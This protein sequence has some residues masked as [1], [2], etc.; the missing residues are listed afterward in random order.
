MAHVREKCTT[1]VTLDLKKNS[2]QSL[3]L[4]SIDTQ[5]PKLKGDDVHEVPPSP[6]KSTEG[7][8][9]GGK[10]TLDF[11]NCPKGRLHVEHAKECHSACCSAIRFQENGSLLSS[12]SSKV[13]K[14]IATEGRIPLATILENEAAQEGLDTDKLLLSTRKKKMTSVSGESTL[15]TTASKSCMP[16]TFRPLLVD[17]VCFSSSFLSLFP[18]SLEYFTWLEDRLLPSMV[19]GEVP[20]TLSSLLR[21]YLPPRVRLSFTS[22][23]QGLPSAPL[24]VSSKTKTSLTSCVSNELS[25]TASTISPEQKRM[26]QEQEYFDD[27]RA[28]EERRREKALWWAQ[29]YEE[30]FFARSL[31]FSSGLLCCLIKRKALGRQAEVSLRAS[32]ALPA[33]ST[34]D[35][36]ASLA[37]FSYAYYHGFPVS[38]YFFIP[39]LAL[40]IF[41]V[42]RHK[43]QMECSKK[44]PSEKEDHQRQ[45][46]L[47]Q[48]QISHYKRREPQQESCRKGSVQQKNGKEAFSLPSSPFF[49]SYKEMINEVEPV[50]EEELQR[51]NDSIVKMMDIILQDD[52]IRKIF[53]KYPTN[54]Q[55]LLLL[56]SCTLLAWK[57]VDAGASVKFLHSYA[58]Q[59]QT[60]PFTTT[61]FSIPRRSL[62]LQHSTHYPPT[63]RSKQHRRPHSFERKLSPTV[64]PIAECHPRLSSP[65]VPVCS[66]PS[67]GEERNCLDNFS[68][69][70]RSDIVHMERFVFRMTKFRIGHPPL[71]WRVAV[72]L[73]RLYFADHCS[74]QIK[75]KVDQLK[76]QQ[77]ER[78][79]GLLEREEESSYSPTTLVDSIRSHPIDPAFLHLEQKLLDENAIFMHNGLECML[80]DMMS[81][82]LLPSSRASLQTLL[83][84]VFSST[85]AVT[86]EKE[87]DSTENSTDTEHK[88]HSFSEGCFVCSNEKSMSENSAT[89]PLLSHPLLGF[90]LAARHGVPI[91]WMLSLTTEGEREKFSMAIQQLLCFIEAARKVEDGAGSSRG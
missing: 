72:E 61:L 80:T 31:S 32:D 25:F 85:A 43:M 57:V 82:L 15:F 28:K 1:K 91:L 2:T 86:A 22:L 68:F 58:T 26:S 71:W 73:F 56:V 70:S 39:F 78:K 75:E 50:V 34:K 87:E 59:R 6:P 79:M 40:Q 49:H 66:R 47:E 8:T 44:S 23:I 33:S 62:L 30:E 74:A 11:R 51:N 13:Q 76:R 67:L 48:E 27:E 90:A 37:S 42:L 63:D 12:L 24:P 10:R 77:Q 4:G 60:H 52:P 89:S 46:A 83:S 41:S 18:S 55:T 3:P 38:Q 81:F 35:P 36:H 45:Y 19:R 69:V 5:K 17:K 53:F 65:S 54:T 64:L 7:K 14:R 21:L 88:S 9:E 84:G 20:G 16:L 29:S